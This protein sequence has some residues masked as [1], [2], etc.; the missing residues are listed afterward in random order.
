[1]YVMAV[2]SGRREGDY[3]ELVLMPSFGGYRPDPFAL[4]I[5]LQMQ[6]KR[7]GLQAAWSI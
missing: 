6:N 2:S 4:G 1:M 3:I 7:T 5:C